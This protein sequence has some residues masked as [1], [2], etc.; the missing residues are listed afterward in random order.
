MKKSVLFI[1]AILASTWMSAQ[2]VIG[3]FNPMPVGGFVKQVQLQDTAFYTVT[4]QNKG[5]QP[6]TGAIS[7]KTEIDTGNGYIPFQLDSFFIPGNNPLAA[8]DT[9]SFQ[10]QFF[11]YSSP[12]ITTSGQGNIVVIWPVNGV[13]SFIDTFWVNINTGIYDNPGVFEE[14]TIY[15]VPADRQLNLN[16]NGRNVWIEQVRI[17]DMRGS[18]V[19]SQLG[20]N[21]SV[22][23]QNLPAGT[24]IL[25]IQLDTGQ[26]GMY[27]IIKR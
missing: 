25:E 5:N 20:N 22:N 15:P 24:Y 17:I 27:Q 19:T 23:L 12:G 21:R 18:V 16:W 7:I 13:D 14:L 2:A 9:A 26:K 6:F 10:M 1:C 11:P 4:V 8:N 3:L